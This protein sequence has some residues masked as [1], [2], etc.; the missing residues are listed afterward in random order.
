MR[1][2]YVFF[3]LD[4]FK[5]FVYVYKELVDNSLNLFFLVWFIQLLG[6]RLI[7]QMLFCTDVFLVLFC[8]SL[9][10]SC[11]I[12]QRC[13]KFSINLKLNFMVFVHMVYM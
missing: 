7:Q 13:A 10:S 12:F 9:K 1:E 8:M 6:I 11:G 5:I 3:Y 2:M 4:D